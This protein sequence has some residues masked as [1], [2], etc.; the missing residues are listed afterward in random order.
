MP[1]VINYSAGLGNEDV[2]LREGNTN[3]TFK[4]AY[5]QWTAWVLLLLAFLFYLPRYEYNNT[6]YDHMMMT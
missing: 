5:Y 3:C 4:L 1:S 2:C 6:W